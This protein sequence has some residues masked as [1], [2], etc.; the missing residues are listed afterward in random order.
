MADKKTYI[1]LLK[2]KYLLFFTEKPKKKGS[3]TSEVKLFETAGK[4]S[5]SD[6]IKWKDADHESTLIKEVEGWE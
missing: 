1:V 5:A 3:Y 6:I 4:T 2:N